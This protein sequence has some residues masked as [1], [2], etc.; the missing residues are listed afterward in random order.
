MQGFAGAKKQVYN[1][2]LLVGGSWSN[3]RD[4]VGIVVSFQSSVNLIEIGMH[5]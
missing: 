2:Q 4:I 5:L 3:A 1:I